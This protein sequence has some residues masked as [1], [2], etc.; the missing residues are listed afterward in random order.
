MAIWAVLYLV[1]GLVSKLFDFDVPAL[2]IPGVVAFAAVAGV[3]WLIGEG[4]AGFRDD[5]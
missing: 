3:L 4:I 1:S 2:S 5:D